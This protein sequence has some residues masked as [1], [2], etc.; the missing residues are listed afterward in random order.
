MSKLKSLLLAFGTLFLLAGCSDVEVLNAKGPMA[1]DQRFWIISSFIFMIALV[2][3][4]LILFSIFTSKYRYNTTRE[5]V[6]L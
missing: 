6:I 2:E 4:D 5:F 1:S 3:V